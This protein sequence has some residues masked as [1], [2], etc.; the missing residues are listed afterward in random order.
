MKD[1]NNCKISKSDEEFINK[2]NKIFTSCK[3]CRIEYVKEQQRLKEIKEQVENKKTCKTCKKDKELNEFFNNQL[4]KSEFCKSCRNEYV[5]NKNKD[6]NFRC[7]LN[8]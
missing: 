7:L 4:K 1:C 6:N 2:E 5:N 8:D 3:S